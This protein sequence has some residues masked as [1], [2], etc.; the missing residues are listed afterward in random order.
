MAFMQI[1]N[2]A[3]QVFSRFDTSNKIRFDEKGYTV[4]YQD[5]LVLKFCKFSPELAEAYRLNGSRAFSLTR[6]QVSG[7][8]WNTK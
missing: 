1:I 6:A 4:Y 7:C 2:E 8:F 5:N 3:K